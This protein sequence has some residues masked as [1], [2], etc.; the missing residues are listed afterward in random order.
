MSQNVPQKGL[1]WRIR[2]QNG[3]RYPLDGPKMDQDAPTCSR[4]VQHRPTFS[5]D[6]PR[7][8]QEPQDWLEMG[9][10]GP[11]MAPRWPQDGPKMAPRWPKAT[12]KMAP[13]SV[14]KTGREEMSSCLEKVQNYKTVI[15]TRCF[16][17]KE[18]P[19]PSPRITNGPDCVP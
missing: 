9:P 19:P 2:P 4:G 15:C 13:T 5:Q 6:G 12:P 11:T 1:R 8:P 14:S 3:P 7:W 10:D 16:A 17:R 18:N